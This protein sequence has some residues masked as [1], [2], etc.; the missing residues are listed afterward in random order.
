[1]NITYFQDLEGPTVIVCI[2]FATEKILVGGRPFISH[3]VQND[4]EAHLPSILTYTVTRTAGAW[5]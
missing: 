1:M 2:I 5:N 3:D 4:T